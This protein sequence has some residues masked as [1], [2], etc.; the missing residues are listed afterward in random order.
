MQQINTKCGGKKDEF[1]GGK[2]LQQ[3]E[4]KDKFLFKKKNKK[5][6]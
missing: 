6:L 1:F 2:L 4:S 5:I 3:S